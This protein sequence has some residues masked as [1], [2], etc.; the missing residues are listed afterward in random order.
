[1]DEMQ[2]ITQDFLNESSEMLEGLDNKFV[3]LEKAPE[4]LQLL[5]DIFRSVHTVKGAAGFLGFKQLVEVA[6]STEN[7]LKKLRDGEM[8]ANPAIMDVV[9]EGVDFIKLLLNNIR[10]NNRKEE[11][12]SGITGRLNEILDTGGQGDGTGG[13]EKPGPEGV[14]TENVSSVLQPATPNPSSQL[15]RPFK[16][17]VHQPADQTI[18]VDT[19]RLDDVMNLV[20]ELVLGRN[21]LVKLNSMVEGTDWEPAPVFNEVASHIDLITTDLQL[22]VMKTRMQPIGKVFGKFPRLVRDLAR[23]SNK[24]IELLLSGEETEVDKSVVEEI[25]DPLV[26]LVRNAIDHGIEH[27]GDRERIGKPRGGRIGLAAYQEGDHIKIE[28]SDDGKGIDPAVIRAK[29]VEKG[30]LTE[31]DSAKMD[32]REILGLIFIPGFSTAKEVTDISGRGVGMDVVKTSISRLNGTV[33]IDSRVGRGTRFSI[34]LPLTMAI[35][36][37]LMVGVG[38]EVFAIPLSN[39]LEAIRVAPSD[40]HSVEGMEVIT[41]RESVLPVIR[42]SEQFHI[43]TQECERSYIVVV[44]ANGKSYGLLVNRLIGQEEVVIKPLDSCVKS[45]EE[46]AGATITGDGKVVLILDVVKMINRLMEERMGKR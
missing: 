1:M 17:E 10:D 24:E 5:N 8:R 29:A 19:K 23:V 27:P 22:A 2:E 46:V 9:L 11:D 7:I 34:K 42:L 21:R 15:D 43:A 12:I 6:H 25:G 13:R 39:V 40:F 31:A 4:D 36:Q 38:N 20:G 3:E 44:T 33:E 28:V 18:R 41:L 37:T 16:V 45:A 35:I 26:H 32:D 30:L 14:E